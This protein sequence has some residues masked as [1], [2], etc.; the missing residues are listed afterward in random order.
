[1]KNL[2]LVFGVATFALA[3]M[4]SV[5]IVNVVRPS[6]LSD[7]EFQLPDKHRGDSQLALDLEAFIE[8]DQS[9]TG[10]ASPAWSN[11][12]V[13]ARGAKSVMRYWNSS[14]SQDVAAFPEDFQDAWNDHMDAWGDFA[15]YLDENKGRAMSRDEFKSETFEL[16]REISR[17]WTVVLRSARSHGAHVK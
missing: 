7:C 17:T 5:G 13:S 1:M 14:V 9:N 15:K 3:F 12:A 16:N 10:S 2:K 8:R 6:G 11:G 4:V